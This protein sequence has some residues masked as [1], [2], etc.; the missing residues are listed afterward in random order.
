MFML[1]F[2][3][4]ILQ[5]YKSHVMR[6]FLTQLDYNIMYNVNTIDIQVGKLV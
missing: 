1:V 5:L 6:K 4:I 2:N 3:K